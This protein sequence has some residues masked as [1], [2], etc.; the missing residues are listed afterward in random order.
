MSQVHNSEQPKRAQKPNDYIKT[1]YNVLIQYI[2][3][4]V[5]NKLF[6]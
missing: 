3:F 5:K 1:I 2:Y 4:F 6:L